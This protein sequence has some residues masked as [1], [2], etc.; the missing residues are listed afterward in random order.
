[1][2]NVTPD[3]LPMAKGLGIRNASYVSQDREDKMQMDRVEKACEEEYWSLSDV[4]F[5]VT[6][7]IVQKLLK[8]Y[9]LRN[10]GLFCVFL[11]SVF[12]SF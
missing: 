6:E 4:I 10:Q 2:R 5:H 7:M 3:L 12:S 9:P 8:Y 1:M 11:A